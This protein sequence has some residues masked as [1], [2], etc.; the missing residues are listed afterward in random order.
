M[1]ISRETKFH[2]YVAR[3]P[4]GFY[5]GVLDNREKIPHEALIFFDGS[6]VLYQGYRVRNPQFRGAVA[7]RWVLP[8]TMP[9]FTWGEMLD[10]DGLDS[11]YSTIIQVLR[12]RPGRW[13]GLDAHGG[14][15]AHL[16]DQGAS[17]VFRCRQWWKGDH[18]KVN[19]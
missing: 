19:P 7:G 10:S 13:R 18:V 17:D 5:L 16:T 9:S 6:W 8:V 2:G 1:P 14:L 11:P 3:I 12:E 4:V 15:V